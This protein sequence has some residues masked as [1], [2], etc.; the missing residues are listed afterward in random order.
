MSRSG[1]CTDDRQFLERGVSILHVISNP[2]PRV[3]HTLAVSSLDHAEQVSDPMAARQDDASVLSLT[4]LRRWNR[5]LRVF[6]A[7]YLGLTPEASMTQLRDLPIEGRRSTDELV[8]LTLC[9]RI[10]PPLTR[11]WVVA[12]ARLKCFADAIDTYLGTRY[13]CID[14]YATKSLPVHLAEDQVHRPDDGDSIRQE[15]VA[16][17]EVGSGKMGETR[18]ADLASVRS[19]GSVRDDEYAHLALG[20]LDG[21]VRLARRDSVTL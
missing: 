10:S 15:V 19:V 18:C 9:R 20:C 4:A 6:T 11:F 12:P 16:H 13:R 5:I 2:F 3:W 7:E 8:R 1:Q 14:Y 17:H 21:G